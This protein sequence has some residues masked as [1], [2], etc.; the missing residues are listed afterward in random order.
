MMETRRF[1]ALRVGRSDFQA[2]FSGKPGWGEPG[3]FM[4]L[5]H[6]I[7]DL[8]KGSS[9]FCACG[10]CSD[11]RFWFCIVLGVIFNVDGLTLSGFEV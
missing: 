7:N 6:R 10:Q 2:G 9:K 4:P 5:S 3:F 8:A 11:D 1:A